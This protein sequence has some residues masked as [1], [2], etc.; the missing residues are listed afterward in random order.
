MKRRGAV[1]GTAAGCL[2]LGGCS[3]ACLSLAA[4]WLDADGKP[5]VS[6]RPCGDD[7]VRRLSLSSPED[8][9][10]S[11]DS[12]WETRDVRSGDVTF[13]LFSPPR[14]WNVDRRGPQQL[15]AGRTYW[16]SGSVGHGDSVDHYIVVTFSPA[17]LA[18]LKPGQVWADNR[19]MSREDF[20]GS[21]GDT[22]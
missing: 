22:C 16:F 18:R 17:D 15:V 13:P 14:S 4:V 7:R 10:T 1:L 19:A 11:D 6:V 2:L 5:V 20:D 9:G 3:P 12:F 21:L 8:P